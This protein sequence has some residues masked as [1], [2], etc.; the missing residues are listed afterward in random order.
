MYLNFK[1]QIPKLKGKIS[2]QSTRSGTYIHYVLER[3]YDPQ[4]KH[5]VPR[6]VLIGKC[7]DE[8]ETMVPNENFL[9]YFP[10][11]ILPE[12]RET[13]RRCRT[14][15]AGSCIVIDRIVE[16]YGLGTMLQKHF[17]DQAGLVLDLA[18]SM[19]I[20]EE[21]EDLCFRDY[22]YRHPLFSKDLRMEGD[23]AMFSFLSSVTSDQI[24]G[25]LNDW[26]AKRDHRTRIYI[27]CNAE[28]QN[29]EA[30]DVG[31]VEAGNARVDL[32]HPILRV[33][34]AFDKTN[35]EP[36]FYECCPGSINDVSQ[37]K[38]LA[39]EAI[40]RRFRRIGFILDRGSYSRDCIA[41]M[42]EH[43]YAF[44]MMVKGSALF[45]A[46]LVDKV[47]G[48]FENRADAS[49]RELCIC[50]ITEKMKLF[51][52]D[53][54]ERYFHFFF[55]PMRMAEER[56]DLETALTLMQKS[57]EQCIGRRVDFGAPH[58]DYFDARYDDRGC[59]LCAEEKK[60]AIEAAYSRC[61][62]FCIITSEKMDAEDAYR[63]YHGRDASEKLLSA[64]KPLQVCSGIRMHSAEV[65][66]AKIFIKFIALIIR[67]RIYNLLKDEKIQLPDKR[68]CMTVSEAIRELEKV[69]LVQI[70]D[71]RYQ[72][73][74]AFTSMQEIILKSFGITKEQV[75]S[76]AAALS[77]A[78]G[79]QEGRHGER[80]TV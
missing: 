19:I 3:S 62:Y 56:R 77:G 14:L 69:E 4:K 43:D 52:E 27:S 11:A 15:M 71:G 39:D 80:E 17:H 32:G 63:L 41:W 72:L 54:K 51:P 42:G 70:N 9:V 25:F 10:N 35:Q 34:V 64:A 7:V 46:G 45:A 55:D 5:T 47:H 29:S 65:V 6:R 21:N 78:L 37:F 57:F 31:F 67:Q 36:L 13:A 30:G 16:E 68:D 58:A 8:T 49:L 61:G 12:A 75:A 73:D 66:S 1:V 48:S 79:R 59:F 24:S 26:S 76:Q 22:A 33:G 44:I 23:A 74:H 28:Y 40:A 60:D 20:E 2:R 53:T 38:L 18:A 50:G